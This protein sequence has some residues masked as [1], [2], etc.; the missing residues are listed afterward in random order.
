MMKEG[1]LKAVIS[2]FNQNV[3][4]KKK[5][6]ILFNSFPAYSDNSRAIYEYICKYRKDI[7][8]KY[9][10]IWMQDEP[11]FFYRNE[12]QEKGS[13]IKKKSIKGVVCFLRAKYVFTTHGYFDNVY[14]G[15][16]QTI[17]N[18]W[19]GCGYK[20]NQEKDKKYLGDFSVV[21][22]EVYISPHADLFRIAPDSILITGLP[23]N[24]WLFE[25]KDVLK[26][27]EI[28]AEK[29]NKVLIWMP[30]YRKAAFAH[31][32]VDGSTIGFGVD[33]LKENMA[34]LSEVLEMRNYFMIVKIHPM[35]EV[36]LGAIHNSERI[37]VLTDEYMRSRDIN[38]YHLLPQ[39]DGLISD[40]SSVIVDYLLLHKPIA[41]FAKDLNDYEMT[42]GFIFEEI[43]NYMPGPV[44][45]SDKDFYDYIKNM[46]KWDKD[47]VKKREKVLGIMHKYQDGDSSKRVTEYFFG[48]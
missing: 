20:D 16:N 42:R 32:D 8:S 45:N 35:D 31:E 47:Y 26:H 2:F 28:N 15:K 37:L 38:L 3:F 18:L 6:I 11:A 7:C 33:S 34:L 1:F 24:D 22:G 19:H 12:L 25:K 40:Y 48:K 43:Y 27:L 41:I 29:Y 44:L 21:T 17:I 9:K 4:V 13:L 14:S 39:T 46:D 5:N 23:R 10:L 36:A 30:T